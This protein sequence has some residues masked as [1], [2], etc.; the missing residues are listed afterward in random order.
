MHLASLAWLVAGQ[1][2]RTANETGTGVIVA[3]VRTSLRLYL[4][5]DVLENT[6]NFINALK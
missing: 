6:V 3:G 4:M 2:P 1:A 5:C